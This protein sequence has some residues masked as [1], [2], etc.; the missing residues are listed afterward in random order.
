[1]SA[2]IHR[3]GELPGTGLPLMFIDSVLPG[4]LRM[5]YAIIGDTASEDPDFQPHI[6]T[7]H[8]FQIG[9]FWAPPGN[10]PAW[11][12]HDYIE[13]FMPLTQPFHFYW[14]TNPDDPDELAG[15][16]LLEPFDCISMPAGLWRRFECAGSE[17]GWG[18]AV[19]EPHEV[20]ESKDPHWP[21]FIVRS[22][23]ENGLD[24]DELGRMIK[25]DDFDRL[26]QETAE[27]IGFSPELEARAA[28]G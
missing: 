22:A 25:P 16:A 2:Q 12:T 3:H 6:R 26:E 23:R 11:H 14:G 1:M 19:L 7:P 27:R 24:V 5:N 21:D 20:F 28:R 15:D 18:F 4:H 17:G 13:M 8:K 10:G 9:K